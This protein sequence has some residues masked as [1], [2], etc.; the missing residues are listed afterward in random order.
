MTSSRLAYEDCKS[1]QPLDNSSE[2][3]ARLVSPITV[4]TSGACGLHSVAVM[5]TL[6]KQREPWGNQ[7]CGPLTTVS[8]YWQLMTP[9]IHLPTHIPEI[10]NPSGNA[11]HGAG[12][13][14]DDTWWQNWNNAPE[15]ES[16]M[17]DSHVTETKGKLNPW[18]TNVN[19]RLVSKS[20]K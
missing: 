1:R 2:T 11:S 7:K 8:I 14:F 10:P 6:A 20:G 5:Q 17:G 18:G 19:Y 9:P 4:Q 3:S 15:M 13:P 16:R 12:E